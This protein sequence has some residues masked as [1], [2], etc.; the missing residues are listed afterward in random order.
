ME[1]SKMTDVELRELNEALVT[2]I[3]RRKEAEKD[4]ASEELI[5]LLDRV[6]EL[7]EQYNF[8]IACYD[9]YNE[10]ID[11]AHDFEFRE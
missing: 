2:E 9:G 3:N 6:N 10:W 5:R 8:E 1:F 7:Q 11:S 4:L